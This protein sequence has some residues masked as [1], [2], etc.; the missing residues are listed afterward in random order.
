MVRIHSPLLNTEELPIDNV[1][2]FLS[3]LR[4]VSRGKLKDI[5][6]EVR[7]LR[8]FVLKDGSIPFPYLDS[9]FSSHY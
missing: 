5:Q 2:Q 8:A 7:E 9:F 1:E 4:F 6:F 3:V